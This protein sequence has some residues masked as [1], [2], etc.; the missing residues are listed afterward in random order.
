MIARN[1]IR[2]IDHCVL[3]DHKEMVPGSGLVC[4]VTNEKPNFS[5]VCTKYR[6][7]NV[8]RSTLE[9]T[10][11]S[12]ETLK[13]TKSSVLIN[14][15][16]YLSLSILVITGAYFLHTYVLDKGVLSVLPL[17]IGVAGITL[18]G[19]AFGPLNY[20]RNNI[21][22]LKRKL[23]K[24]GAVMNLN[25]ISHSYEI[26]F[27]KEIHLK[28]KMQAKCHN[29]NIYTKAELKIGEEFSFKRPNSLGLNFCS[30]SL[31]LNVPFLYLHYLP[32]LQWCD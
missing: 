16:L 11:E 32:N 28:P 15:I 26:K 14:F 9:E 31:Q 13:R 1:E 6:G 30:E 18:L 8:L 17:I 21:K 12:Y 24:I 20:Y 22:I 5:G 27:I 19:I 10:L 7:Q 29:L 23:D 25:N 2:E 4:T 3:C